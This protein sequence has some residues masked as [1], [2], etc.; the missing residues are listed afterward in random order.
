MGPC[1]P[2]IFT[3]TLNTYSVRPVRHI[4]PFVEPD[5]LLLQLISPTLIVNVDKNVI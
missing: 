1:Y 4:G 2:F 3:T 5:F